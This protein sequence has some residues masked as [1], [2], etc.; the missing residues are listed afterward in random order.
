MD[1]LI[2]PR[3]E[4]NTII[5]YEWY[6][7]NSKNEAYKS[8]VN[9]DNL[10]IVFKEISDWHDEFYDYQTF[11]EFFKENYEEYLVISGQK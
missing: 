8:K 9:I 3:V 5:S 11:D 4:K 2:I 10:E 6:W 1:I 7:N